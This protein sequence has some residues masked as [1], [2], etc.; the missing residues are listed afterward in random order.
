M[1]NPH[2]L[3]AVQIT[4]GALLDQVSDWNYGAA[5][6]QMLLGGDG[7][8]DAKFTAVGMQEPTL[9]FSTSAIATVLGACGISGLK[10]ATANA[11]IA[12][13]QQTDEGGTR[14]S[15]SDHVKFTMNEGILVPRRISASTD[16]NT[17]AIIT[18][19]AI[20]TYDGTNAP[21]VL[22]AS[23]ALAGSP[24][25]DEVFVAGPVSVNGS[26]LGMVQN[27]EIDFG[28]D[29]RTL[30]GD[31]HVWPKYC[32]IANRRPSIRV[33]VLDPT[34]LTT[35][36]LSGAAQSTT[37]SVIYLRKVAEG[38]TRVAD[39]TSEHISFTVDEGHMQV[40]DIRGSQGE[41]LVA[42]LLITP[43]YDGQNDILVIDTTAAIS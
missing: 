4:G 28:L 32:H 13:M 2:V 7:G 38:G 31:G 25:L 36:G 11:V 16:G 17:P 6:R 29:V 30:A 40:S 19:D 33:T 37:D 22:A 42:D 12:W 8:V 18:L 14:K 27:I 24:G 39:G 3:Y 9:S 35:L 20:A 10:I 15:G 41:H 23:Q 21:F 26:S 5:I 1:A 34:I 43:T